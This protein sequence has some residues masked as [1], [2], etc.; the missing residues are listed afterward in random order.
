MSFNKNRAR[1]I[2]TAL[3]GQWFGNYGLA[4][5]PV[6]NDNRPSLSLSDG[7]DGRLLACCHAGCSFDD[8]IH[9][10]RCIGLIDGAGLHYGRNLIEPEVLKE[11]RHQQ[12][13][14]ENLRLGR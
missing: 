7:K 13:G 6:H 2:T 9:E 14:Y 3:H 10:L 8:I 11:H 4:R 12:A 5:C 1:E